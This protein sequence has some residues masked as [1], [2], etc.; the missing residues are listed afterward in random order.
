MT[1]VESDI[2]PLFSVNV[3]CFLFNNFKQKEI[4]NFVYELKDT[5][6]S[7]QRSNNNGWQ[8][9]NLY[10]DYKEHYIVSHISDLIEEGIQEV[11]YE[12]QFNSEAVKCMS[13][14]SA[15]WA[16]FNP[17]GASNDFHHHGN[18]GYSGVLYIQKRSDGTDGNI[19]FQ[20]TRKEAL[21]WEVPRQEVE[22]NEKNFERF[23]HRGLTAESGV[24]FI[25]PSYVNHR[26]TKNLSQNDRISFSFNFNWYPV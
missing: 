19:E 7:V 16:N 5:I 21:L 23:H 4:T 9:P 1:Y 26:V 2:I 18:T 8:S 6:P 13:G 10:S 24:M 22:Y 25:F 14:I 11:E 15:L 17:P 20:D 12:W 3:F